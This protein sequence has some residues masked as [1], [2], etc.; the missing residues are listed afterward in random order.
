MEHFPNISITDLEIEKEFTQ[1]KIEKSL[2]NPEDVFAEHELSEEARFSNFQTYENII[3]DEKNILGSGNAAIVFKESE[4]S[5]LK[6]VWEKLDIAI[7]NNRTEKLP[8][9]LKRL[10]SI[11]EYFQE[12]KAKKRHLTSKGLRFE[13][14]NS[15][16][17]EAGLQIVAR[18]IL[19]KEGLEKMVPQFYTVLNLKEEDEGEEGGLP[20]DA[21]QDVYLMSMEE[22]KGKNL[23]EIILK[24]SDSPEIIE[25]LD[26][27]NIENKLTR[28]LDLFHKQGLFHKDISLR[29][30]MIDF[31]TGDPIWIDFGKSK[32][33]QNSDTDKEDDIESLRK[34]M[35]HL[36][37]FL[38]N[39][40]L[41]STS[42]KED[43]SNF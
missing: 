8:S 28:S 26:I 32:Y 16:L 21:V 9:N 17:K 31:Q 41:K 15:A 40:K 18:E 24:Y 7:K 5:C 29:N 34:T 1:E 2:Q 30:I 11:Q 3:Q 37:Q 35:S 4:N 43:Y 36:K 22:I 39:P 13:P 14:D 23:E 20:Y 38:A 33:S 6:C 27:S 12:I 25:K 19:K 10:H 42:L